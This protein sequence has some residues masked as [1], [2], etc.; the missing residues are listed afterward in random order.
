M[1]TFERLTHFDREYA[2][3]TAE[4]Q[5]AFREAVLMF[6]ADLRSPAGVPARLTGEAGTG[7]HGRVGDDVGSR[8]PHYLA[9]RARA[10]AGRAACHMATDR[11]SLDLQAAVSPVKPVVRRRRDN[12]GTGPYRVVMRT[13]SPAIVDGG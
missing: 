11:D 2:K 4:Q 9:V 8:R 7:D 10:T 1:P 3:L 12:I 13:S 6:V 5:K